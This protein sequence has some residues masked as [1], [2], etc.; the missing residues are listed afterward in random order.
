MAKR[1]LGISFSSFDLKMLALIF[2]VIDHISFYFTDMPLWLRYLGRIAYPLFL[3]C[4]VWSY[5]YTHSRVQ[6]CLRLYLM[7]L[8]MAAFRWWVEWRWP[9][10]MGFGNRNIFVNLLLTCLLISIIELAGRDKL[11][12]GLLLGGLAAVQLAFYNLPW[13][14]LPPLRRLSGDYLTAIFPNLALNEFGFMFAALGAAM[15]FLKDKPARL[16][17]VYLL[18]CL[19]Q[20][21]NET[22]QKGELMQ[23]F[24]VLALPFM[25]AYNRR[26]GRGWKW[27]FYIFYPA[28]AFIL[29]Y[30]G[31]FIFK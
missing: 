24:M 27:F 12:C 9:T 15:Y 10:E 4:L 16:A 18:F 29:F 1:S 22:L 7:G 26:R 6:F 5:H 17:A 25:L 19:Y 14:L 13:Y 3:F 28:H 21:S 30:L 8:F 23:F 2:M 31:N 11:R 20:F